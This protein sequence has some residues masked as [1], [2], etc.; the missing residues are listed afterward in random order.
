[1]V[2]PELVLVGVTMIWG[3]TFLIIQHA[4]A[5]SGPWCFI[6]LR[7]A[8]AALVAA[9]LAAKARRWPNRAELVAGVLVGLCIFLGHALQTHGLKTIP[10]S[11]SAFIT[12]L[13][14]PS[15]PV[16]Q[17]LVLRRAPTLAAWLGIG[18]AFA[19]LVLLA[20]PEGRAIG[21][22]LGEA[23]TLL[24][25]VIFAAEIILIGRYAGRV[26]VRRVTVVQLG[27]TALLAFAA[28]AFAG[29]PM[30]RPSWLLAASAIGLGVASTFIQLAMNWAQ[31]TVTP[32]RATVIYA[33]EPV[34]AGIIGRIAGERLPAA[35]LLGAAL[36][37][38]GIIVSKA[39]GVAP[40]PHQGPPAFGG[41]RA[42]PWPCLPTS[43]SGSCCDRW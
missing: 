25:A 3:A 40:R 26:D 2:M 36:I 6:G 30:P 34:W 27:L 39:R 23:L 41:P 33:G 12:A 28:M 10:S 13:Y 31:Q 16:L 11:K 15:V 8:S 35:A 20:G 37:V 7:F 29:E 32:T 14:V 38:A 42:E 43:R 19:G 22:G 21:L 9:L 4:L 5:V 24:G 18:L 1:M 17:W